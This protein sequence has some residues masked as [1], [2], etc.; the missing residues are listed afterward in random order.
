MGQI[1]IC[2][3]DKSAQRDQGNRMQ[4]IESANPLVTSKGS[5]LNDAGKC[6]T[7]TGQIHN[8]GV[9][10]SVR[11]D[12]DRKTTATM[13]T[14]AGHKRN[15]WTIGWEQQIQV[16]L[17][18][19]AVQL[20]TGSP[21][22]ACSLLSQCNTISNQIITWRYNVV[23]YNWSSSLWTIHVYNAMKCRLRQFIRK[24]EILYLPISE[25]STL[26]LYPMHTIIFGIIFQKLSPL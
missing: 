12:D 2:G 26:Q 16:N 22:L 11:R 21:L 3:T 7:Q 17:V 8:G 10:K 5:L 14:N 13:L 15:K 9:S 20:A 23:Q 18:L 19:Q 4:M 6:E 1:R 25:L 24:F